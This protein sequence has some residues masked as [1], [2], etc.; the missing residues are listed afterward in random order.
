M[1]LAFQS[2][3]VHCVISV[4]PDSAGIPTADSTEL[5]AFLADSA[6]LAGARQLA[7]GGIENHIHILLSLPPTLAP[8]EA[9]EQMKLL[10]TRWIRGTYPGCRSFTWE[11]GYT[12]FSVGATQM[13]ETIAYIERQLEC[14]RK[15]DYR[16][17]LDLFGEAHHLSAAAALER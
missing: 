5:H 12:E 3:L 1:S 8:S 17:E 9:I 4:A 11:D 14:H 7:A 6:E 15:I 13:R 2:N 10:S 16:T